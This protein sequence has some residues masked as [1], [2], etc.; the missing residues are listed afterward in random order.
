MPFVNNPHAHLR[1]EKVNAR[2]VDEFLQ[3]FLG[4]LPVCASPYQ[5]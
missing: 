1:A 5:Q 2:F 3:G 4:P